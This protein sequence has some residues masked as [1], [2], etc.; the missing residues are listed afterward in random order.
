MSTATLPETAEETKAKY[1]EEFEAQASGEIV[2]D[3][4]VEACGVTCG[5]TCCTL[6]II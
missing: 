1:D 4:T 5:G 3:D 2:Q 6:T